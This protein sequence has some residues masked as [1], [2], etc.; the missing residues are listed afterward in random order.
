[1]FKILL[2][3]GFIL[4]RLQHGGCKHFVTARKT[5]LRALKFQGVMILRNALISEELR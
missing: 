5:T 1:M 4:W 3:F 2:Q